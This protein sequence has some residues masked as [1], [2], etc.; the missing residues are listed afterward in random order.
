MNHRSAFP[1]ATGRRDSCLAN[2]KPR[3]APTVTCRRPRRSRPPPLPV[4]IEA[5]GGL[6]LA[7][8]PTPTRETLFGRLGLPQTVGLRK[9]AATACPLREAAVVVLERHV[10]QARLPVQ[11]DQLGSL[12]GAG[13]ARR[14][15]DVEAPRVRADQV[16]RQGGLRRSLGTQSMSPNPGVPSGTKRPTAA[17]AARQVG[18][19]GQPTPGRYGASEKMF[20]GGPGSGTSGGRLT[21]V[22]P[23]GVSSFTASGPATHSTLQGR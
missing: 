7:S 16:L 1:R 13:K 14:R 19:S 6:L 5:F 21:P 4:T 9:R 11:L 23:P 2:A 15:H 10:P 22:A 20:L 8:L 3:Q 17:T 12:F 18:T